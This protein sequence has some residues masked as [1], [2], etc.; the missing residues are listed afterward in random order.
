[1]HRITSYNVC[2]TKLLRAALAADIKASYAQKSLPTAARRLNY[3]LHNGRSLV[4]GT[5]RKLPDA[6]ENWTEA[7][8]S[9]N[10]RWA[11]PETW[12]AVARASGPFTGYFRITSYNV[13]YTKLL[14]ARGMPMTLLTDVSLLRAQAYVDGSWR[15]AASGKT[16]PVKNPATGAVIGEVADLTPEEVSAAIDAADAAFPAWAAKTAKERAAILRKWYDLI[17]ASADDLARL[18]TAEQGKPLAEAKGE[19]IYGASFV[20]W[21]AEE[22]RRVYG[23]VVLV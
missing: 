11:D 21:F 19:V 9:A 18:M 20:E 1:M 17:L 23:D 16:F 4:F 7:V 15:S 14:R 10:Q 2:Y 6:A 22:A 12:G 3:D 8:I 5:A 13:C